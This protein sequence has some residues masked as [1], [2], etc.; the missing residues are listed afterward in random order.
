VI[1]AEPNSA[2]DDD[3]S[4][5]PQCIQNLEALSTKE[6]SSLEFERAVNIAFRILGFQVLQLGQGTG[7]N[8]DAIALDINNRF[9][10]IVDAK[11]RRESYSLG[12]DDRT[13]IEYFK[14]W[15]SKLRSKGMEQL[16]LCIISSRFKNI[17][18]K[19]VTNIKNGTDAKEV[20]LV[21]SQQLLK[22]VIAKIKYSSQ[23]ELKDLKEM[24]VT[25]GEL[26][27]KRL[28]EWIEGM[29]KK[30]NANIVI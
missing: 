12:T 28:V 1:A 17:N 26:S 5:L 13:F 30:Y 8:P 18:E 23:F 15:Q 25:D 4:Y 29:D 21:T 9:A 24:L 6:G 11:S 19:A 10:V 7:R 3:N 2:A 20:N 16:F 14:T 27:S 22:L